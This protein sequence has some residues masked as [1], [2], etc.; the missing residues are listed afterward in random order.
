MLYR[1]FCSPTLLLLLSALF[2]NPRVQNATIFFQIESDSKLHIKGTSNVTDF[3]CKCA[4]AFPRLQMTIVP[5]G[6][7]TSF[8]KTALSI[9]AKKLDCGNKAMNKDMYETMKADE[10]PNIAIELLESEV[11]ALN[12]DWASLQ[13]SANITIAG[14]TRK[15]SFSIQAKKTDALQYRFKSAKSLKMSDYGMTPPRPMFGLIKVKDL[16]ILDLDLNV[17]I[18]EKM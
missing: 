9:R 12:D 7:K 11:S 13:A 4:E 15:E 17:S 10:Y 14:V 3:T 2:L 18:L 5:K 8:D 16:I 1:T 6:S